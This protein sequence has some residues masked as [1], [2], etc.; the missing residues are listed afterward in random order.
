MRERQWESESLERSENEW[1]GGWGDR[2][3]RRACVESLQESRDR[4]NGHCGG[5]RGRGGGK[6]QAAV[7]VASVV[8]V[9]GAHL[10]SWH[11]HA[12]CFGCAAG[13]RAAAAEPC[14]VRGG[15]GVSGGQRE[16]ERERERRGGGSGGYER[17]GLGGQGGWGEWRMEAEDKSRRTG[18]ADRGWD[19]EQGARGQEQS[20]RGCA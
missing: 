11:L 6:R 19:H 8:V 5:H 7:A 1:R 9:V 10:V 4:D 16:R 12:H 15:N 2:E 20:R 13:L 14:S 3:G 18:Q 17:W